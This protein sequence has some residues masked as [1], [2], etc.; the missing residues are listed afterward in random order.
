VKP[1]VATH[2]GLFDLE[3]AT[4]LPIR[5]AWVML[6]TV[7][8]REGRFRWRPRML[9]ADVLPFDVLDFELVLDALAGAGFIQRYEANG[10]KYGYIP[11]WHS[12]QSINLRESASKLPPPHALTAGAVKVQRM[13]MRAHGEG[14]G[15]RE[16]EGER[17][18]ELEGERMACAPVP[19]TAV[20]VVAPL[21]PGRFEYS[22]GQIRAAGPGLIGAWNNVA[23]TVPE[24]S[25][26]AVTASGEHPKV[27]TALRAHPDI[28]WWADV[29]QKV[30][31]SDLLRGLQ[32]WRNGDLKATDFWWCLRNADEIAAGSYDNHD[33]V[34][35]PAAPVASRAQQR[36]LRNAAAAE[37]VIASLRAEEEPA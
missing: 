30:A 8:D 24:L 26:R 7:C 32:P 15:E 27:Y 23:A 10:E 29:F 22:P 11:T 19:S 18:R 2:E 13:H 28:N 20:V 33:R 17:E 3:Q 34:L 6:W 12:H 36:S 16:L 1:E 4:N 31:K 14:E 5:F 25:C 21:E 35:L 9:K 37:A